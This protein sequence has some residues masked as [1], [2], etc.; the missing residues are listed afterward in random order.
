MIIFCIMYLPNVAEVTRPTNTKATK[1]I[2]FVR[3]D[4]TIIVQIFASY[5]ILNQMRWTQIAK[6]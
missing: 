1:T 3:A 5:L 6:Q 2:K 4:L